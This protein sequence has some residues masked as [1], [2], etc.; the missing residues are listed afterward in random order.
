NI[1]HVEGGVDPI[2]DIELIQLELIF[3]D[4]ESLEKRLPNMEK[5]AKTDKEILK[6]VNIAKKVLDILKEGKPARNFEADGDE[7][8]K[9]LKNLQLITSKPQLYVCNLTDSELEGNEH[10]Q[11]VDEFAKSKGSI[12][13]KICAQIEAEISALESE[14][15][16]QEFLETIG[17]EETGL[18]QIIKNAYQL[19]ELITFFTV[20]PKECRAWNVRHGSLAPQ[21]AGVIHSDFEKGF[22]RAETISCDDYIALN[23]E[24]GAKA[25]GKLRLE[26]KEY[27]CQDGDVF[28]F[29]FNV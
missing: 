5:K 18:S 16:K 13:L 4:L 20:G 28:H 10:S 7:E 3:A 12:A 19:L 27:Y 17:L 2:R 9:L 8:R 29:R 11:K 22:I 24:E 15:E 6:E 23:G 1:T 21:A 14:E 25:A 26:G